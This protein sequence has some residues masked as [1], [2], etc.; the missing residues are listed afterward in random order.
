MKRDEQR[1]D[2]ELIELGEVT[3]QTEGQY[4]EEGEGTM[5]TYD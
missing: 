2:D 3:A 1:F 4:G 5:R